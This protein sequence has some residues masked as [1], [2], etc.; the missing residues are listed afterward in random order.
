MT[1]T[2]LDKVLRLSGRMYVPGYERVTP[3]GHPVH[4]GGYWRTGSAV[5][6]VF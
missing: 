5:D 6:K 1:E 2:S 4:V 3:K